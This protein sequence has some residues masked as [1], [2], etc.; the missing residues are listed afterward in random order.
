ML[1]RSEAANTCEAPL[2][3]KLRSVMGFVPREMRLRSLSAPAR[4]RCRQLIR[5]VTHFRT[6][7]TMHNLYKLSVTKYQK[8]FQL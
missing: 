1:G 6:K 7:I 3:R 2:L 8:G 4:E 5:F